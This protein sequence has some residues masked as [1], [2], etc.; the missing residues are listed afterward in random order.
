MLHVA[1]FFRLTNLQSL[2]KQKQLSKDL[3]NKTRTK[4]KTD[5]QQLEQMVEGESELA[6][7]D[8]SD[9]NELAPS[10]D[11]GPRLEDEIPPPVVSLHFPNNFVYHQRI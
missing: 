10:D 8:H 5:G 11:E 6:S 2:H 9:Y 3:K 4:E 7:P 1:Y